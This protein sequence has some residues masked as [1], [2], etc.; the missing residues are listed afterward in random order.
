MKLKTHKHVIVLIAAFAATV[1]LYVWFLHS[2]YFDGFKFW[3][4]NNIWLYIPLLAFM[5]IIGI[6]W[7]PIPGG[8]FTLGSIPV[9]GWLSAYLT[10]LAGSI[11][12]S[13]IAFFLAKKYGQNFMKRIRIH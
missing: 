5:K 8:V 11:V 10:D 9:L 6:V 3:S 12:G 1:I 2:R 13:S 4:Q 7:P